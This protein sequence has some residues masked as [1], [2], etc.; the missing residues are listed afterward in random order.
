MH[1]A[2]IRGLAIH[3]IATVTGMV[4]VVPTVTRAITI[5][6]AVVAKV[7]AKATV[8]TVGLGRSLVV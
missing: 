4:V 1:I 2:P 7:I 8:D 3:A 5:V 6:A